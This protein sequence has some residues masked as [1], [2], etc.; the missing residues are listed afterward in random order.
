MLVEMDSNYFYAVKFYIAVSVI[1]HAR[2]ATEQMHLTFDN[3][4]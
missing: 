2:Y 3:I 4:H 1:L